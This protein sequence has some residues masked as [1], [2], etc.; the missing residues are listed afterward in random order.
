METT[1]TAPARKHFNSLFQYKAIITRDG[2]RQ[3]STEFSDWFANDESARA[4]YAAIMASQGYKV[5][6]VTIGFPL[7]TVELF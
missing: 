4:G 6:S 7:S 5:R 3:S 2:E 1:I